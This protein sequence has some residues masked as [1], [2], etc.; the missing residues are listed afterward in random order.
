MVVDE[1]AVH[2]FQA[3]PGN[4]SL[5]VAACLDVNPKCFDVKYRPNIAVSSANGLA[6]L[7]GRGGLGE[8]QQPV[9]DA[10]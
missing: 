4:I 10:S 5:A 7:F 1:T 2:G 9:C 6:T 8:H 3:A